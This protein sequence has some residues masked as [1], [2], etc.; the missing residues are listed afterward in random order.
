M[1]PSGRPL[2]YCCDER[3]SGRAL[4]LGAH[5]ALIS[6]SPQEISDAGCAARGPPL[7]HCSQHVSQF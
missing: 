6:S 5:L 7:H 3:R 4:P 2:V 1:S